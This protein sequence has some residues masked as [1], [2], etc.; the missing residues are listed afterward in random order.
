LLA[1][2]GTNRP[3]GSGASGINAKIIV[4][5]RKHRQNP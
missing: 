3:L 4:G 2:S 1:L 5:Y